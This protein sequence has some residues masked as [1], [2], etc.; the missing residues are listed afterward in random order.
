[1]T[2]LKTETGYTLLK[3]S[4][5]Y[6]QYAGFE[7]VTVTDVPILRIGESYPPPKIRMDS[8]INAA[9]AKQILKRNIPIR[10]KELK[11]FRKD[12]LNL[13]LEHFAK[14]LN[15]TLVT[16]FKWE[17]DPYQR[18]HLINEVAVRA[19]LKEKMNFKF[20]L[21]LNKSAHLYDQNNFKTFKVSA[22]NLVKFNEL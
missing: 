1:M 9:V 4:H 20:N 16:I 7:Y 15:V 8:K 6:L 21:Q 13:S 2:K 12:V 5:T 11:F 3:K 10:G 19:L 14:E 17:K 18:L 22:K